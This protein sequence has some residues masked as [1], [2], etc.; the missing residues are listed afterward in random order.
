MKRAFDKAMTSKTY[1]RKDKV[2]NFD[3]PGELEDTQEATPDEFVE[4]RE[5]RPGKGGVSA[6]HGTEG[7]KTF[8]G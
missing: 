3:E 6:I 1:G 4:E 7:R 8:R 2:A 5:E